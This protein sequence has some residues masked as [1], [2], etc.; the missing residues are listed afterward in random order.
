WPLSLEATPRT[1]GSAPLHLQRRLDAAGTD[2]T[3]TD[4]CF[5]G[6]EQS[7]EDKD[8]CEEGCF[9]NETPPRQEK[10]DRDAAAGNATFA[11]DAR[12]HLRS[13]ADFSSHTLDCLGVDCQQHACNQAVGNFE[14]QT[15]SAS[16]VCSMTKLIA[17]VA[18][19][20]FA[21]G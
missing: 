14:R 17:L 5:K 13:D 21:A 18:A 11:V 10:N 8:C 16:L 1:R 7:D 4:P 15:E 9:G 3:P 20:M 2:G 12:F 19:G 6:T